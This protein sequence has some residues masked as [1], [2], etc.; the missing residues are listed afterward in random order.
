MKATVARFVS[1]VVVTFAILLGSRSARA[2]CGFYV[3]GA[4]VEMLN[5]ATQVV[6]MRDGERTILTMQNNYQGPPQR[7]AMVVPVPV[8]LSKE[9]VKTVPREIFERLD[10]LDSPRLVEY[11]EQD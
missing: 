10:T 6:L 2:F 3:G 5:N 8:V 4:G 11:W 7:F 1:V 9:T